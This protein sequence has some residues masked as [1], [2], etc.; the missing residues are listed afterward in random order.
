[1]YIHNMKGI[2][3][4][5]NL[6]NNKIYI[7]SSKNINKRLTV[8]K[9]R[10][11][12]NTHINKHLQ[13]AYNKY[14]INNFEFKYLKEIP[15]SLLRRA[16]QFY[17]NK[18][19]SLDPKYGYNKAMVVSNMHDNLSYK[20]NEKVIKKNTIYFGCYTKQ[21]KLFKV[22][23]TI[24]EIDNYF[25]KNRIKRIYE[26]CNSNLT[27]TAEGF[28]W[29][30]YNISNSKFPLFVDVKFRKGRH[31]KII[32]KTLNDEFIKEWNSAVEAAKNLKLSS[33]NITRCLKKNNLYKNYKWYY[34]AP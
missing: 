4:I 15:E 6:V 34:S 11:F 19:K 1:M 10:L 12:G 5:K 24:N 30:R 27:K 17:I 20:S 21:G 13:N 25:N 18:Y 31:K 8:H 29:I 3:I 9:S 32:Q 26:S 22:F 2:Y 23:R 33:F 28:Y 7:G 14:G 16:E